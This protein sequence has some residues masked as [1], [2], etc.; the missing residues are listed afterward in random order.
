MSRPVETPV[1]ADV[2]IVGSGFAGSILARILA[3]QG[4]SVVLFERDRHPRF[5]LGESSTPLAAI[6]L[7]R[8]SE[9]HDLPDLADLA[10]WGRWQQRLPKLRCGLKRG[11][12][13]YRHHDLEPGV[14][15]RQRLL[16]AAS[17]DDEI[18]DC[19]WMRSDVDSFL[20][21][22]AV[23]AGVDYRDRTR[24]T[25][26]DLGDI[27]VVV[28][29]RGDSGEGTVSADFLVDA[30]GSV[31]LL[32]GTGIRVMRPDIGS[33][34]TIA[35]H[36]DGV[37]GV[38]ESAAAEG[39]E[40]GPFPDDRAAVHHLLDEGWVYA[41][42]F[43]DGRVSAGLELRRE[44]S[45]KLSSRTAEDAWRTVIDRYPALRRAFSTAVRVAPAECS[46]LEPMP[47]RLE[48]VS[49]RR[50]LA[51]PHTAVF[52]GPLFSTGIA[53][54]LLGVERAVSI[55]GCG[56]RERSKWID[57]YDGLLQREA[58][59]V[60]GLQRTAWRCMQEFE[61]FEVLAHLYFAAAS[62]CEVRQ[63]LLDP[64]H[65]AGWAW[66]GFLGATDGPL[67][68]AFS[69]ADSACRALSTTEWRRWVAE[70][71]AGRDLIGLDDRRLVGVDLEALRERIG[72]IGLDGG[73]F[74]RRAGRLRGR[75]T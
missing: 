18:A 48:T 73:D 13:F 16:V 47:R 39:W 9:S 24:V 41:L 71:I 6:A 69:D 34:R 5:A 35:G 25:R 2:A 53:W 45:E 72:L 36:F 51:L 32:E 11:F 33:G 30:S 46:W 37:V 70:R 74:D 57:R 28:G 31:S 43:D 22:R 12:T 29:W 38:G 40:R 23:E 44:A 62:W 49:G 15:E 27:E 55:L 54:S 60:E 58:D 19:Q 1:R 75:L 8:L 61:R 68:A 17:P 4:K 7:E 50:W 10:A 20:V 59:H 56:G 42:R 63:R 65:A 52:Y 14:D 67:S 66:E 64:E 21:D 26:V 3:G